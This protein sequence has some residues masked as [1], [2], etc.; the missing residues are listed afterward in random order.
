MY[1]PTSVYPHFLAYFNELTGGPD[2]GYLY[3]V[4]S[5]L[6]WGQDLKR[7]SRWVKENNIEKIHLDYFGWSDPVYYLGTKFQ[8]LTAG[9]YRNAQDFINQTG[10]GYLAVS[11]TFY[12]GSRENPATSYAWL[13]SF[14]PV[15]VIGNSIWVWELR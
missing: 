4:D 13:D 12:M 9:Q 14:K 11:A 2:K 6:D 3:V 15:A 10:G 5:N 8:W 1:L 7:L